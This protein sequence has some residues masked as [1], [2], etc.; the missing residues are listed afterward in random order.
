MRAVIPPDE[1]VLTITTLDVAIQPG[2]TGQPIFRIDHDVLP[3]VEDVRDRGHL[4]V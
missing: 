2:H 4:V 1:T 3:K